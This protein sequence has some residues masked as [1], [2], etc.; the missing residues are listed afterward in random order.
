MSSI[1]IKKQD[2]KSSAVLDALFRPVMAAPT[3]EA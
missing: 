2:F 1:E 3:T